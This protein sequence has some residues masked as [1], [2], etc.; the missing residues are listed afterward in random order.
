MIG[1]PEIQ[2]AAV[3]FCREKLEKGRNE[4]KL[5]GAT[6]FSFPHRVGGFPVFHTGLPN[7]SD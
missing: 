4:T 6:V 5:F 3:S 2:R 1:A 7:A